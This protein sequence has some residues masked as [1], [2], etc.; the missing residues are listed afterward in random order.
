MVHITVMKVGMKTAGDV[1]S[2]S[3]HQPSSLQYPLR[4]AHP[5]KKNKYCTRSFPLQSITPHSRRLS[6]N[7]HLTEHRSPPSVLNSPRSSSAFVFTK[8]MHTYILANPKHTTTACQPPFL[9]SSNLHEPT[10]IYSPRRRVDLVIH[11]ERKKGSIHPKKLNRHMWHTS[12]WRKAK[13]TE[14]ACTRAYFLLCIL[15]S[16]D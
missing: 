10:T 7:L 16:T 3:V 1:I 8:S 5:Y 13:G 6:R 2:C 11:Q 4:T 12:A 15:R 9:H 14:E